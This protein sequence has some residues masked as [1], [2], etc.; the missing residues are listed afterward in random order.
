LLLAIGESERQVELMRQ[1]LGEQPD[2]EPYAAYTRLDENRKGKVDEVDLLYFLEGNGIPV[3]QAETRAV[4]HKYDLDEDGLLSYN[5]FLEM[6]LP[7]SDPDLR[8]VICQ[9]PNDEVRRHEVLSHEIEYALSSLIHLEIKLKKIE[10]KT[11]IKK[12]FQQS[13]FF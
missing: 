9:R 7:S 8:A 5:E 10:K 4:F 12:S 11:F 2:F 6:V 13:F 3:E 1:I